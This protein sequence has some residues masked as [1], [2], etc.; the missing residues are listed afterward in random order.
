MHKLMICPQEVEGPVRINIAAYEG[1]RLYQV[2][3][4][5]KREGVALFEDLNYFQKGTQIQPSFQKI[6]PLQADLRQHVGHLLQ[7]LQKT[8]DRHRKHLSHILICIS[9]T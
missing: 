3:L 9:V 1:W 4:V 7:V 5:L 2:Q 8:V 6:L